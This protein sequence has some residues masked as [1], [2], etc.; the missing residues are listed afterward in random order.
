MFGS[1]GNPNPTPRRQ[2][3]PEAS[4]ASSSPNM[5]LTLSV[6]LADNPLD[7]RVGDLLIVSLQHHHVPIAMDPVLR[8]R[9]PIWLRPRLG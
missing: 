4:L 1:R 9:E 6:C 5:Q 7:D 8:Q 2:V 3:R